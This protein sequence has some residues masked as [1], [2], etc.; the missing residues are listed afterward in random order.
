MLSHLDDL[1]AGDED[2]MLIKEQLELKRRAREELQEKRRINLSQLEANLSK[3]KAWQAKLDAASGLRGLVPVFPVGDSILEPFWPQGLGSNRG[4]HTAI[5]AVWAVRVL[6][7]EGL[8]AALL[9]R[10]FAY[11]LMIAQV[12]SSLAHLPR[13]PAPAPPPATRTGTHT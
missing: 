5:D 9:E 8:Q 12:S 2:E 4:F 11:D 7:A 13:T 1:E 10:N 3:Q 6:V